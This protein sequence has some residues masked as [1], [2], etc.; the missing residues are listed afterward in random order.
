MI[1]SDPGVN[2]T[3]GSDDGAIDAIVATGAGGAKML[4]GIATAIL[5]L[6]WLAFYLLIFAPRSAPL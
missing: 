4:A 6:L 1:N 2:R 5:V 3:C